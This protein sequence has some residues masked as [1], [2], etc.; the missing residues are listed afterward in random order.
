M[1]KNIQKKSSLISRV[2][3]FDFSS[4]KKKI[5]QIQLNTTPPTSSSRREFTIYLLSN[6]EVAFPSIIPIPIHV[7]QLLEANTCLK[8]WLRLSLCCWWWWRNSKSRHARRRR[9]S[10]GVLALRACEYLTNNYRIASCVCGKYQGIP[11]CQKI[12]CVQKK[13]RI[14]ISDKKS[15]FVGTVCALRI[16]QWL[17]NITIWQ[18]G[19][20]A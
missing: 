1:E 5:A 11:E 19:K 12:L 13:I 3:F 16:V 10:R 6:S 18:L 2:A 8:F 9:K 20:S 15:Q 17:Y 14:S 7:V 4:N